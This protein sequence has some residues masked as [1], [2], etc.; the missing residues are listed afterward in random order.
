MQGNIVIKHY[1]ENIPYTYTGYTFGLML[2]IFYLI[3]LEVDADILT[4]L[5]G[6]YVCTYIHTV[7]GRF[8][9]TVVLVYSHSGAEVPWTFISRIGWYQIE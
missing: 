7:Q 3:I 1:E 8:I 5:G 6:I 9:S 2:F 4:D